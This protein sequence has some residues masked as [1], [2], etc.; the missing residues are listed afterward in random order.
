[1]RD[2]SSI[3]RARKSIAAQRRWALSTPEQR[4][5]QTQRAREA[6]YAKFLA[7]VDEAVPG[8]TETERH[9]RAGVLM[10]AHFQEMRVKSQA[11]A[12]REGRG[13]QP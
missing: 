13:I 11:A 8:L 3:A 1:M 9:R 4:Q 5:K 6:F 2:P 7:Q 12:R 10:S